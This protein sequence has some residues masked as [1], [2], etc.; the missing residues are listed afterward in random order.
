[1]THK[2]RFASWSAPALWRF[3][4]PHGLPYG[5]R[6]SPLRGWELKFEQ[7]FVLRGK[8]VGGYRT[9]RRW[10]VKR[11]PPNLAKRLGLRQPSGALGGGMAHPMASDAVLCAGEK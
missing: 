6:C 8:A 9:P 4:E 7:L 10:R 11:C 1:M 3:V 2:P 5:D